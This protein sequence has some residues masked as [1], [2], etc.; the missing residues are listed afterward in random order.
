MNAKQMEIRLDNLAKARKAKAPAKQLSIHE[1]IRNLSSDHPLHFRKVQAWIRANQDEALTLRREVRRK[2]N[3]RYN[4]QLNIL[5]VY[6]LNMKQYLRSGIWLDH[7]YGA[8][9]EFKIGWRV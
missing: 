7:K 9:R 8:E 1:S 3:R 2:Y 6:I 4:N 5:E